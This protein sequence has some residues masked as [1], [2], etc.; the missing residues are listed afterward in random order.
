M[1][2]TKTI[3]VDGQTPLNADNLN[4]LEAGVEAA[5]NSGDTTHTSHVILQ[6]R[7]RSW[8]PVFNPE[9]GH[10]IMTPIVQGFNTK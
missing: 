2:Y 1:S 3:W 10:V 6:K 4:K 5:H 8:G 9:T 7:V